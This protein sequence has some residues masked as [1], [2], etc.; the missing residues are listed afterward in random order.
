MTA[1]ASGSAAPSGSDGSVAQTE[2]S[3]G[4]GS[5]EARLVGT[6]RVLAVLKELGNHPEGVTLDDLTRLVGS[7]K[8]SV[9]RALGSLRKAGLADQDDNGRYHIGD[10]LL[11]IA[12][13]FNEARPVH[14][15]MQPTLEALALRFAETAHFAVL[16]GRDIVYRAKVDPPHGAVRLTSV[17]GGRNPAHATAVGKLLLAHQLPTR[18]AVA[19]WV[20][21]HVLERRTAVTR[22]TVDGL[23]EELEFARLHGYAVDNQENEVGVNC[24]AVPVYSSSTQRPTGAVSISAVAYRTPLAELTA[25][26]D[27]IRSLLGP[28]GTAHPT[29]SRDQDEHDDDQ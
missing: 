29:T 11:R 28:L 12:F 3:P 14:V 4:T 18:D 16:D 20:G 22:C 9:H 21:E 23:H 15:R 27:D 2:A 19:E 1:S 13:T 26:L 8:P 17:I 10:E 5:D 7:P 24:L 6:E 25:A